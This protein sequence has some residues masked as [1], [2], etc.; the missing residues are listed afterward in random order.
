M[1]RRLA[2][3]TALALACLALLGAGCSK[4]EDEAAPSACV[5][6]TDAYLA[7][8]ETA[9]GEVRL[10]GDVPI[11]DCLTPEQEG[12]QLATIGSQ[13]VAAATTLNKAVQQNPTGPEAVQL[14]YLVGAV[15]RGAEG[16]HADLVRRLNA[17]ARYSPEGLLPAE[18]E[19]TFGEGYNAGLESG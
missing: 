6:G 9:P 5:G 14:G 8:L 12:G 4:D 7:A 11:S 16:I 10:D 3:P 13:M 18:F 2:A 15:E 17:A 19:G 1:P